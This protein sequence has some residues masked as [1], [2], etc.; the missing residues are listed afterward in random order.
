MSFL[1]PN[2][3]VPKSTGLYAKLDDGDN[4]F[5]ILS[6]VT[7]GYQYWNTDNKCI[8]LPEMPKS[9]P[10]DIGTDNE[11][12]QKKVQHFWAFAV[13]NLSTK[14]IQ[15]LEITQKRLM[16][17]LMDLSRDTDWGDP[18][19]KYQV[20]IKKS[21][22]KTETTFQAIPSPFT[23]DM[24]AIKQMYEESDIDMSKYFDKDEKDNPMVSANPYGI[25]DEPNPDD[26]KM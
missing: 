7:L 24:P 4:K 3:E 16:K 20:N 22:Q 5:I 18:I 1:D 23:G 9:V 11:G 6:S 8:R 14:Q 12:K 10:T 19:F 2:Y 21:G 13:Y 15:I 26:I 17:A 25:D